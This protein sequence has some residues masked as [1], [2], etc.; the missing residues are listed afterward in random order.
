MIVRGLLPRALS[1]FATAALLVVPLGCPSEPEPA[2]V[3]PIVDPLSRPAEPTLSVGSFLPSSDC[4]ECHPDH[5]ASWAT[6]SHAYAMVDPVFRALVEVRRADFDGAQDSFCLQCHTAIGTRGG[7]IVPGFSWSELSPVVQEG[8]TC[9]ACHR[10]S[11][12]ERPW[13]S[14]HVLDETGPMRGSFEGPEASP[15]HESV[16]SALHT[17]SDFCGGCHDVIELSGLQLE[18]P[19]E[20]WLESPSAEAGQPCQ[21]CHMPEYAG[22]AAEGAAERT[23]HDHGFVGIDVPLAEGFATPEAVEALRGRI[24]VLLDGAAELE[25]SAEPVPAGQPLNLVVTAHNLIDG[26]NL[27]TG[28]T[29]LRQLW[30]ELTV[31]DADGAV[32]YETGHLDGNE[33]LRDH[34]S[35][36]DPYGDPDLLTYGSRLTGPDGSPELFPWRATEHTSSSIPPRHPRTSTLFV[37]T[38]EQLMGPLEVTARLRL[39]THPP[40]L[41]RALGLD[42]LLERVETWDLAEATLQVELP[43]P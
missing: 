31:R 32:I 18:R 34:W 2:P 3:D 22:P 7:E 41:L 39:R 26:H 29:F 20:E 9:S 25:L 43:T 35:E 13:N 19:Y 36:L 24:G 33:D 37:P 27:P 28:S 15:A 1:A 17:R 16:Y 14:G 42:E 23:L 40:Y 38:T 8:V 30:L 12:L 5:A 4:A 10:V 6:S 21:A 11:G